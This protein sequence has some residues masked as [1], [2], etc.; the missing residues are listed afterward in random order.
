MSIS[1]FIKDELSGRKCFI[2]SKIGYILKP[3]GE[4]IPLRNGIITIREIEVLMNGELDF[5]DLKNERVYTVMFDIDGKEKR[6]PVNI[7]SFQILTDYVYGDIY[8][9]RKEVIV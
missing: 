7:F 4:V 5:A 8:I 2:K 3:S 1:D 9:V 6:L